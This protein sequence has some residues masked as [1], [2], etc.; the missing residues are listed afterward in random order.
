DFDQQVAKLNLDTRQVYIRVRVPETARTDID[1]ISELRVP[2]R[3]GLVP[4]S[5]VAE[6]TFENGPVQ[7]DRYDR[8]RYVEVTADLHGMPLRATRQQA[9]Q[10]PSRVALPDPVRRTNTGYA[11]LC[12][13][14]LRGFNVALVT[15]LLCIFGA[16]VL[17]LRDFLHPFTSLAVIA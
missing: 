8:S 1:T 10:W 15:A 12:T 7:I 9:N 5:S 17:L 6:I 13:E 3:N 11:E 4:L 16:L 14:L 2:G